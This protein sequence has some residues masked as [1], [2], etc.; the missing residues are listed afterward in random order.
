MRIKNFGNSAVAGVD[1]A[2]SDRQA[3]LRAMHRVKVRPAAAVTSGWGT[4]V[5]RSDKRSVHAWL[6]GKGD[7]RAIWWNLYSRVYVALVP[8]ADLERVMYSFHRVH[9]AVTLGLLSYIASVT[10]TTG[11][12]K[13]QGLAAAV[14]AAVADGAHGQR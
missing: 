2:S 14:R 3:A 4:D 9:H 10:K 13:Q 1:F 7:L 8:G 6:N 5:A 12:I 11:D